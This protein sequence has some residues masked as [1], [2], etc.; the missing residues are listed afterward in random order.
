MVG[1]RLTQ[2][3]GVE[4]PIICGAM[5]PCSN[6]DLVAAAA[7]G[8]GMAIIQPVSLTV[9]HGFD[10]PDLNQGLLDGIRYIRSKTDKP[11]GFNA[12]IEKG[13]DKYLERMSQWIDIALDE[14]IRFFVTSLGKPDWVCERVHAKG[15]FVYHDVT[16]RLHAE[17]GV[18]C[19]VDGLIC[20]NDRAGGHLGTDSMEAMFEELADLGLPLICA[21]G[22]GSEK[23]LKEAL[24]IGY[25]G[26]QMGTRFIATTECTM[27]EGYKDAI[28][29]SGED[30]IDWTVKLTGI[31]V[32]VI[33]T[34]GYK[35]ENPWIVR[36]LL[37]GRMK[38][39][40]R[41]IM[42]T[43]SFRR[44]QR[45]SKGSK[46]SNE[47]WSAGKSVETIHS[48]DS[49]TTIMRGLGESLG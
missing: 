1:N 48:V 49:A 3:A 46:S 38:H 6:P 8:G 10:K 26:V 13:N 7:E 19:G 22:I 15:G 36:K 9:V 17:K 24:R 4:F 45:M 12:L 18:D 35:R 31:P 34:P 2:H 47:I 37:S 23:E 42:N 32:S 44:W 33:K 39:R 25:D 16:T 29:S 27:P 21:G 41:W 11:L 30:D 28:V 5:Y 43:V 40:T 14:G 20:V